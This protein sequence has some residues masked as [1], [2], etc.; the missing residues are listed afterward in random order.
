M[1]EVTQKSQKSYKVMKVLTVKVLKV[2]QVLFS[3]HKCLPLVLSALQRHIASH[4]P[5]FVRPAPVCLASEAY[6]G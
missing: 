2:L 4:L 3:H 6:A 5:L 1:L